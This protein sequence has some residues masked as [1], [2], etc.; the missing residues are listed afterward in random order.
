MGKV[1]QNNQGQCAV[2]AHFPDGRNRLSGVGL[3]R[4]GASYLTGASEAFYEASG[5]G[6]QKLS[7]NRCATC[8]S[9]DCSDHPSRHGGICNLWGKRKSSHSDKAS[10]AERIVRVKL[11]YEDGMAQVGGA[12]LAERGRHTYPAGRFHGYTLAKVAAAWGALMFAFS[13]LYSC[14]AQSDC[15]WPDEKVR[16]RLIAEMKAL[17]EVKVS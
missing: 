8:P 16:Y 1:W 14:N 12:E 7:G 17:G 2:F 6:H 15:P 9:T 10:D 11:V 3:V 13:V 4:L 5:K